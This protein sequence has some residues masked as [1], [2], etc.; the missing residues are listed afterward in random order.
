MN[1]AATKPLVSVVI[2]TYNRAALVRRA[3]ESALAQNEGRLEVVVS[4]DCSPDHTVEFLSS[5][6]DPRVEVQRQSANVG[7]WENWTA[8]LHR[9][10][11][12][13]V[14][15]LGDD[16]WLSPNFVS[17]HLELLSQ[18]QTLT[19]TFSPMTEVSSQ[20]EPGR[21]FV[22]AMP[23]RGR[24]GQVDFLRPVLACN[25]FFGAAIFRREAAVRFWAQT[26][27]DDW[28]ADVGLMLR[29]ALDPTVTVSAV[30]GCEYF[31]TMSQKNASHAQLSGQYLKVT[32]ALHD[33]LLRVLPL[34]HS[35]A[36][37]RLLTWEAGQQAI[38]LARHHAAAGDLRACR[39]WLWK[40][41]Q[42][43]PAQ[44]VVW[45]QLLQSFVCADRLV[46]SARVQRGLSAASD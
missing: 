30:T 37:T 13:F 43:A 40:A 14:I 10:R 31:K 19:A 5:L 3:V 22:P 23:V 46:S 38:V 27:P 45:S 39:R 24:T 35:P 1:S 41:A 9:A 34:S 18:D 36:S 16:D 17:T 26:R 33:V 4:D 44:T 20:G 28:V 7:V 42:L 25:L 11:G 8:A 12:E 2:A 15:F 21:R 6:G 29:M 32:G